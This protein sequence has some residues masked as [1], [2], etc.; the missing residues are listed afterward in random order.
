MGVT[1]FTL[2][3]A[4]EHRGEHFALKI[5]Y[6]ISSERRRQ[7]F[8]EE[9]K[10]LKKQKHPSILGHVDDGFLFPEYGNYPFVVTSYLLIR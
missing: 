10:F 8:L 1:Y 9:V 4:G 3:T 7:R 2:R 6:K 5:F